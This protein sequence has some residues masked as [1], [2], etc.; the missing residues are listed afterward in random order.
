MKK[1]KIGLVLEGGGLRGVFTGGAV[2]FFLDKGIKFD[3]VIGVSAGSCNTCAYVAGLR[4]YAKSCMVQDD[5]RNNF[6]G[7]SQ[8]RDSHKII[9]LDKVF[10]DY[11]IQY[12]LDFKKMIN[13]KIE[14]EMVVSN[15]VTG[16]AE[17]KSE[18]KDIE[19]LKTIGKASC[20]LPLI[21]S[22]IELDE[23]LYLDGGLCDSIPIQ[24]A[25]DQGCDKVVVICTRR[26]NKIPHVS[27]IQ[28]PLYESVYKKYPKLLEAIFDRENS[29]IKENK[30]VD[31]LV[32]K[33]KCVCIRPTLPEVGR[34]ESDQEKLKMYYYHG[35]TKAESYYQD[36]LKLMKTED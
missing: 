33:G 13:N 23:N 17:Y 16:K 3:Y 4:G 7:L 9:D 18:K 20:S 31:N 21:T 19:R 5:P 14:W 32:K 12:G 36:I 34:L 28:K 11:T 15:I 8:M 22:P 24:R 6:F 10:E 29:Y 25:L 1:Q 27:D 2:D 30:L 26:K 35:Y